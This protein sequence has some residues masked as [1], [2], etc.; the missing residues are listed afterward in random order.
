MITG[1]CSCGPAASHELLRGLAELP[2]FI[3]AVVSAALHRSAY[4]ENARSHGDHLAVILLPIARCS[5]LEHAAS[6]QLPCAQYRRR[7]RARR[8]R[9][10][11]ARRRRRATL[12]RGNF[13]GPGSA[14]TTCQDRHL[15]PPAQLRRSRLALPGGDDLSDHLPRAADRSPIFNWYINQTCWRA[16]AQTA[17]RDPGAERPDRGACAALLWRPG[18]TPAASSAKCG[19]LGRRRRP[20]VDVD[21]VECLER[22]IKICGIPH[23]DFVVSRHTPVSRGNAIL[24][25]QAR[26]IPRANR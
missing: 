11:G 16:P 5:S 2:W 7:A 8:S 3:V 15:L 13:P 23:K 4:S 10:G 14:G 25:V 24:A 6:L 26:S 20:H 21:F 9:L 18:S 19:R 12:R 17:E 22:A 1:C